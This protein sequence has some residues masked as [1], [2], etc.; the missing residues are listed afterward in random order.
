MNG[1]LR[2]NDCYFEAHFWFLYGETEDVIIVEI[3]IQL[4]NRCCKYRSNVTGS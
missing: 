4:S 3:L 2:N 1:G